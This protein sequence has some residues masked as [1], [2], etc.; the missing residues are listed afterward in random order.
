[1]AP[2]RTGS[3]VPPEVAA[4]VLDAADALLAVLDARGRVVVWN[5][6]CEAATGLLAASVL[7]RSIARLP[8]ADRATL[9]AA[10]EKPCPPGEAIRV[11]VEWTRAGA[12]A[13][14]IRWTLAPLEVADGAT[15]YTVATGVVVTELRRAE[16]ALATRE[17]ELAAVVEFLPIGYF[18]VAV[19]PDDGTVRATRGNPRYTHITGHDPGVDGPID[20]LEVVHELDRPDAAAAIGAALT[21]GT[22]VDIRLRILRRDGELR[23][24]R[25][26]ATPVRDADGQIATAVCAVIDITDVVDAL[27]RAHNLEQI[28]DASPDLVA[29]CDPDLRITYLNQAAQ[30]LVGPSVLRLGDLLDETSRADLE[31]A[32]LPSVRDRAAWRG[33]MT[34]VT[35]D[36]AKLTVSQLLVGHQGGDGALARISMIARDISDAKALQ[37]ELAHRAFHDPLT[38]LPNRALL[39]DRLDQALHRLD[40]QE[41]QLAVLFLDLD[42]LKAVN[43]ELGHEAGDELLRRSAQRI[44]A[45]V[46]PSDTVARLGGDEFVVAAE[47]SDARE[48]LRV[49]ER[50]RLAL[51]E[52]FV[53]DDQPVD[54]SA[55][56]GVA[57]AGPG[58][59]DVATLLSRADRASYRAKERGRDRTE[60]FTEE[61]P[62]P[63]PARRRHG[64]ASP[65][66]VG[67]D[68][69]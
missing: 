32:A 52:P 2:D 50:V 28:V 17:A 9:E 53:I 1:M 54:S 45:A 40:R 20:V 6:G 15:P 47:L 4:L 35:A 27:Q 44:V 51:A 55:S 22:E 41:G 59:M 14:A 13:E 43:D 62:P 23:W 26:T 10:L 24:V 5:A 7:G 33:E 60:M 49:A 36:G 16:E 3:G 65:P 61:D 48:A 19:D 31:T 34:V 25:T 37:A 46:R 57:L 58:A 29:Q 18:S 39:A 69:G 42:H 63:R 68:P 21:D 12:P 11:E 64:D 67:R 38:G 8:G 30:R 56:I 66:P